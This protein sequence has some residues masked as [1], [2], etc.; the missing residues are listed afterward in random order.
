MLNKADLRGI[1]ASLGRL[2]PPGSPPRTAAEIVEI[3]RLQEVVATAIRTA[4]AV[5]ERG[6]KVFEW[7]I[8]NELAPTMERYAFLRKWA[9]GHLGKKLDDRVQRILEQ[10]VWP[11]AL[12][13]GAQRKRWA[14]VTRF[15]TQRMD[16]V[17]VDVIGGKMPIDTLVRAGILADDS[18]ELLHRDPLWRKTAKGNTHVLIEV[19]ELALEGMGEIDEPRDEPVEHTP[20]KEKKRGPMAAAIVGAGK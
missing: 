17:S 10:A 13:N 20:K 9:K 1:H 16:D 15:S 5:L 11:A 19:Y 8:P 12:L 3:G 7:R 14:R 2:L 6:V 4:A 18:G